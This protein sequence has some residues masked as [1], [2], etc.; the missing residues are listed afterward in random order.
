MNTSSF[1]NVPSLSENNDFPST[2]PS[3]TEPVVLVP[4]SLPVSPPF[5]KKNWIQ[6][7]WLHFA[8][9]RTRLFSL[10][11]FNKFVFLKWFDNK[12]F[13]IDPG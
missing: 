2:F 3:I 6:Q 8:I 7:G 11:F 9:I 4:D 12:M 13:W 1:F 10:E 5:R